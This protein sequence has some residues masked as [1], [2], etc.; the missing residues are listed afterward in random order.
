[1]PGGRSAKNQRNGRDIEQ[2]HRIEK[3]PATP[4]QKARI[5]KITTTTAASATS[6]ST[7]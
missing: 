5:E 3:N 6:F 7:E 1:M 2:Y 4:D